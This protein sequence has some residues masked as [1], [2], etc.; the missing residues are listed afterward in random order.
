MGKGA[1]RAVPTRPESHEPR[2][3]ASLCP[4]YACWPYSSF[5]REVRRGNFREDWGT[6][7]DLPGEFG[8]R[9]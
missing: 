3:H 8:E 6:D 4:P 7:T 2:G 9:R 1:E 5:H